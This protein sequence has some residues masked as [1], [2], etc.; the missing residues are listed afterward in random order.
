MFL[1]RTGSI[2]F[3]LV[4]NYLPAVGAC[5]ASVVVGR[6]GKE[7]HDAHIAVEASA[8]QELHIATLW[9]HLAAYRAT[10]HQYREEDIEALVVMCFTTGNTATAAC[11]FTVAGLTLM[12]PKATWHD[13]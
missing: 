9:E 12:S 3:K 2:V 4:Q 13:S 10:S 8:A 11:C 7:P 5:W 6:A 1:L